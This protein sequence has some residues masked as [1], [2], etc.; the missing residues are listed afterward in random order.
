MRMG[1]DLW[2]SFGYA[3]LGAALVALELVG[4]RRERKG[5]TITENWR[6]VDAAL[7]RHGMLRW[8]WRVFTVG[9]LGWIAL[10][11]GGSWG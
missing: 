10:H 9:F 7:R 2:F 11:F 6:W 1:L 8:F 5:D 3:L 4:V